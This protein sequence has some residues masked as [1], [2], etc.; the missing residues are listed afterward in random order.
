[1]SLSDQD[2]EELVRILGQVMGFGRMMQIAEKVWDAR[3]PGV[4]YSV[5]CCTNFL[6]TCPH[7]ESADGGI[8]EWCCG[9][10]RVTRRVLSA[11]PTKA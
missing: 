10:G 4:A 1:M 9:A 3:R 11:M 6:V 2:E 8:C 7:P 5:G